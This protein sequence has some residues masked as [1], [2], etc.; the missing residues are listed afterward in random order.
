MVCGRV[1]RQG[2]SGNTTNLRA[3]LRCHDV[4][5]MP[6]TPRIVMPPTG[7]LTRSSSGGG[8]GGGSGGGGGVGQGRL[9]GQLIQIQTEDGTVLDIR[10]EAFDSPQDPLGSSQDP[11]GSPQVPLGSVTGPGA[12]KA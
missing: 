12:G 6:V 9:T 3:H 7:V 5:V 10:Q 4:H 2:T 8:G 1:F 11:L